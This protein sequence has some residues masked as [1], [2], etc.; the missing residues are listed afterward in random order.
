MNANKITVQFASAAAWNQTDE[1]MKKRCQMKGGEATGDREKQG[2]KNIRCRK[3]L[4]PRKVSPL[5][6]S[7]TA[8]V[9]CN[10]DSVEE[11]RTG[12]PRM[13][14]ETGDTWRRTKNSLFR[15]KWTFTRRWRESYRGNK[16]RNIGFFFRDQ[17][18]RETGMTGERRG[19]RR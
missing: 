17:L 9:S 15:Q 16:R 6:E 12:G 18:F 10:L 3:N 11:T 2:N 8:C 14:D 13:T 4:G 1:R 19:G 5:C 7:R